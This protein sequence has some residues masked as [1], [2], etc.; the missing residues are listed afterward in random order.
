MMHRQKWNRRRRISSTVGRTAAQFRPI[1]LV[2][3]DHSE[4]TFVPKI[5]E[6]PKRPLKVLSFAKM[7]RY[8]VSSFG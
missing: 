8:V 3:S 2:N 5:L 6:V 4:I 7:F 1:K